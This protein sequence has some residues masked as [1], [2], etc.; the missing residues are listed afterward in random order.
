MNT[1]Q[2]MLT[3]GAVMIF[4]IIILRMN[5]HTASIIGN[6]DDSRFGIM[7]LALARSR[8]DA[9][10]SLKFDANT[11]YT[12]VQPDANGNPIASTLTAPGSL[13][14]NNTETLATYNDFDDFNGLVTQE[15]ALP[16]ARFTVRSTV[17]YVD[18]SDDYEPSSSVQWHKM[19]TVTV[20]SPNLSRPIVMRAIN[21]Y[22]TY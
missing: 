2:M 13:G 9:A 6:V 7:A 3:L 17:A 1:G 10:M 18:P 21:S 4:G 5:T 11:V 8:I 12:N 14:P 20:T 15:N 19:I 22:W 16:S